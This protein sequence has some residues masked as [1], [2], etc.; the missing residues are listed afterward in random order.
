MQL[1]WPPACAIRDSLEGW[2]G[3]VSVPSARGHVLDA[4]RAGMLYKYDATASGRE[5]SVPHIKAFCRV[6]AVRPPLAWPAAPGAVDVRQLLW[7]YTGSHNMSGAAWGVNQGTANKPTEAPM[8][9]FELGIVFLPQHY[10]RACELERQQYADGR[11]TLPGA[12]AGLASASP[13]ATS[14][15]AAASAQAS[16]RDGLA[17]AGGAGDAT[18]VA[19]GSQHLPVTHAASHA[20]VVHSHSRASADARSGSAAAAGGVATPLASPSTSAFFPA[21][22]RAVQ[23]AVNRGHLALPPLRTAQE[24]QQ[25]LL[26]HV[27]HAHPHDDAEPPEVLFP[28]THS[29]QPASFPMTGSRNVADLRPADFPDVPWSSTDEGGRFVGVP[30]VMAPLGADRYGRSCVTGYAAAD[31]RAMPEALPR[32]YPPQGRG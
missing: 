31:V 29:L 17:A 5:L 6:R 28:L 24:F 23:A 8:M 7:C 13:P 3:G 15:A 9:S 30:A 27:L 32:G 2:A 20:H 4:L 1:V 18:D 16:I 26:T 12:S 22:E 25:M 21:F 19:G 14:A 10:S 11:L